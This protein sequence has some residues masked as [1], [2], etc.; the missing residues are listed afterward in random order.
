MENPDRKEKL[1]AAMLLNGHRV[2]FQ[3]D[4]GAAM[5]IL[6]EESFK[7]VY[8][9]GSLSLLDY[10]SVTLVMYNKT[11]EKPIGKKQYNTIQ[12]IRN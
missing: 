3:M 5:N 2:P 10:A 7:E 12:Y 8:G 1:L 4:T 9:E 11:E 6:P